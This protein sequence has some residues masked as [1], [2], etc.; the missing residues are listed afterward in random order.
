VVDDDG[1]RRWLQRSG[2]GELR[3]TKEERDRKKCGP[4]HQL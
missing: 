4:H 3:H 2:V 1:R